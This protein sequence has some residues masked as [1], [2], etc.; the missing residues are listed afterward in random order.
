[1]PKVNH[2]HACEPDEAHERWCPFVRVCS[3][4]PEGGQITSRGEPVDFSDNE[5]RRLQ[6][7]CIS[8]ECMAW[9][10]ADLETAGNLEG[11]CALMGGGN[12]R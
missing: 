9:R 2:N 1:M 11:F 8:S 12:G 7:T 5:K 6:F 4:G 10:W 3:D